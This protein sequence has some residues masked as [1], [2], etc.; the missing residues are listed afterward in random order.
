MN[1]N[2]DGNAMMWGMGWGGALFLVLLILCVAALAKY[3]FFGKRQ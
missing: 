3:L 1:V 2:A